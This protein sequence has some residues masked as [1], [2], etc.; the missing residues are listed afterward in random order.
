M[1][2]AVEKIYEVM[3]KQMLSEYLNISVSTIDWWVFTDQIPSMKLGR[4]RMFSRNDIEKWLKRNASR[5]K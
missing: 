1:G 5:G 3:T 2:A 4:R